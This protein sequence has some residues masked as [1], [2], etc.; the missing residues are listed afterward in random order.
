MSAVN[1]NCLEGMACPECGYT[2]RFKIIAL[3]TATIAD[4]GC[5]DHADFEYDESARCECVGCGHVATVGAFYGRP[6]KLAFP[7]EQRM[8]V[9]STGH[10]T[11]ED[12]EAIPRLIRNGTI[13]GMTREHGWMISVSSND[14]DLPRLHAILNAA[15]ESGFHWVLLDCDGDTVD[16]L[17]VFDW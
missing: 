6:P 11:E 9:I 17:E 8:A 1:T 4:D 3:T 7:E 13:N 14:G 12:S 5:E 15:R 2:E 16:G 10:V